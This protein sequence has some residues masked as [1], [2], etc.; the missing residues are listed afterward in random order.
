MSNQSE[1]KYNDI[2][3]LPHHVSETR[4]RMPVYDR[5]AQFAPFAALTGYADATAETAR[6]TDQ[7]V[8]LEEDKKE[9]LDEKLHILQEC[10]DQIAEVTFVYFVRDEKKAGG[11]YETMTDAIKRIDTYKRMIITKGGHQIPMDDLVEIQGDFEDIAAN[12]AENH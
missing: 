3:D 6:L 8:E 1:Q 2:I 11:T 5:A 10:G 9:I 4:P 12:I 7:K